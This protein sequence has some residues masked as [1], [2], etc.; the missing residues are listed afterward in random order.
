VGLLKA[1]TFPRNLWE[2]PFLHSR[3]RV[4]ITSYRNGIEEERN[5]S[6]HSSPP[7]PHVHPQTYAQPR[8]FV[9]LWRKLRAVSLGNR[10]IQWNWQY[11]LVWY[12][13]LKRYISP[14]SQISVLYKHREYHKIPSLFTSLLRRCNSRSALADRTGHCYLHVNWQRI[15]VGNTSRSDVIWKTPPL[16]LYFKVRSWTDTIHIRSDIIPWR[17]KIGN[18]SVNCSLYDRSSN[19]GRVYAY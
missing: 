11:N 4:F 8:G 14:A 5:F 9:C 6:L 17:N 10:N 1:D 3:L 19:V 7:P 15:L 18:H 16:W 2:G 13:Y 12:N